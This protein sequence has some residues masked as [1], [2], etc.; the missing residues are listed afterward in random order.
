[1]NIDARYRII[2][3]KWKKYTSYIVWRFLRVHICPDDTPWN[4][5]L[6]TALV[7]CDISFVCTINSIGCLYTC[8]G[9]VRIML[10]VPQLTSH[11]LLASGDSLS[12]IHFLCFCFLFIVANKMWEFFMNSVFLF[13]CTSIYDL[14]TKCC[15]LIHFSLHNTYADQ[16]SVNNLLYKRHFLWSCEYVHCELRSLVGGSRQEA[17]HRPRRI[18]IYLF[19]VRYMMSG[20]QLF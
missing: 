8:Y 20:C 5:F 14:L 13:A 18:F 12:E 17:R 4:F 1:M 19:C 6:I 9:S 11:I 3:I 10:Y 2:W 16:I 7:F 15:S